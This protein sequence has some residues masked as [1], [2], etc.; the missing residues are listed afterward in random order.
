[1][2]TGKSVLFWRV[3]G[4]ISAVSIALCACLMALVFHENRRS[5]LINKDYYCSDCYSLSYSDGRIEVHNASTRKMTIKDIDWLF[6][7]DAY[8][9]T[10]VIFSKNQR[11]GFFNRYTGEA[12]IPEQYRHAWIFSEG[13]AAVVK[14]DQI[15]FIDRMGK[16]VIGYQY[17][18]L[19][20]NNKKMDFVFRNGLCVMYDMSEKCGI[21]NKKGDW[22][23]QPCYDYIHNPLYGKRIFVENGK[24]GVCDDSMRVLIPPVYKYLTSHPEYAIV[25]CQNDSKQ[26]LSY[27]GEIINPLVCDDVDRLYYATG[28]Y[29]TNGDEILAFADCNIYSVSNNNGLIDLQ[30]RPLTPPVYHR[31]NAIDKGLFECTLQDLSSVIILNSEGKQVSAIKTIK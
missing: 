30:G 6:A 26:L 4:A 24:Y 13:L 29:N 9:D 21:I 31:I 20:D 19:K 28:Q 7:S 18:Y 12:V 2:K 1:M 22:V 23:I 27:T 11:R 16:I 25:T 10:L 15:G 8:K 14:D 5:Y 17:P 3:V